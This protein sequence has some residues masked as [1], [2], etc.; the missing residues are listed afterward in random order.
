MAEIPYLTLSPPAAV[1]VAVLTVLERE[2]RE[3]PE[4]VREPTA[5]LATREGRGQEVKGTME[6]TPPLI[7]A[8]EAVAQVLWEKMAQAFSETEERGL[9]LLYRAPRLPTREEE[10]GERTQAQTASVGPEEAAREARGQEI[11]SL[12]QPTQVVAAAAERTPIN[13]TE[14]ATELRAARG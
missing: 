6:V 7:S 14:T 4:A 11:L 1:A 5:F 13:P 9:P 10:A 2:L 3:A 12:V 8:R